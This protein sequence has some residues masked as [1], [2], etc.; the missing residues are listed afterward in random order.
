RSAPTP[1]PPA[2]PSLNAGMTIDVD[3]GS[4][5]PRGR[6]DQRPFGVGGGGSP[7]LAQTVPLQLAD[8]ILHALEDLAAARDEVGDE[9]DQEHLETDDEQHGGE[10][11]GL[12][13]SVAAADPVVVEEAQ[14][15]QEAGRQERAAD[16]GEN[17]Q[18]L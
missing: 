12:Q 17:L 10:D 3:P 4:A 2:A 11:Q 5:M 13:L 15:D 14:R 1:P 7:R 18:R 6:P 9:P 8:A 16:V